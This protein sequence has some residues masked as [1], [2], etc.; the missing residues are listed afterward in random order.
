MCKN[1]RSISISSRR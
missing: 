1:C